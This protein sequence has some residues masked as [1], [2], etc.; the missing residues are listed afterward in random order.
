[1]VKKVSL[2]EYFV[3]KTWS[4]TEEWYGS[5]SQDQSGVYS[6]RDPKVVEVLKKQN[7]DF[8]VNFSSIFNKGKEE[9]SK[10]FQE[11]VTAIAQDEA[12]LATPIT[13]IIQEFFRTQEQYLN[14]VEEYA[15]LHKESISLEEITVWKREIVKTFSDIILRFSCENVKAAEEK[16]NAQ[17]QMIIELSSPVI[18]LADKIGLLPLIGEINA[19]RAS[20]MFENTLQKSAKH[21][22]ERLFIDL[23]GV[24][25]IDTMVVHQIFQLIKG[26][27]LIGIQTSL[28]GIRPDIAQTAVNLGIQFKDIEVYSTLAQAFKARELIGN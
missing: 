26:L 20:V 27:N 11:W 28:S 23:S 8:H 10:H 14:L 5:L 9:F 25:V 2:Y 18:I 16:S 6:S 19:Y 21:G 3:E 12:H 15:A 17:Q 7:H 1:M 4:L 22:L 24:P 13:N